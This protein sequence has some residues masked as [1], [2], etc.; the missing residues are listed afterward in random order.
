[1]PPHSPFL[2]QI[3]DLTSPEDKDLRLLFLSILTLH[4]TPHS[5]PWPS[6]SSPKLFCTLT[7]VSLSDCPSSSLFHPGPPVWQTSIRLSDPS[8]DPFLRILISSPPPKRILFYSLCRITGEHLQYT[9]I[10]ACLS[11]TL[12]SLW[13]P[14][15]QKHSNSSWHPRT[16]PM[17]AEGIN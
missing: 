12:T 17:C 3:P 8:K 1:M 16:W 6:T 4:P 15:I 13:A 7:W 14:W 11:P 5:P 9:F 2:V 10:P